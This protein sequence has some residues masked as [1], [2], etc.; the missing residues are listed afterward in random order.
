MLKWKAIRR[1]RR[2]LAEV[3]E[4]LQTVLE[5]IHVSV[6]NTKPVRVSFISL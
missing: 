1:R 3:P 4:E 6:T 5:S 2:N